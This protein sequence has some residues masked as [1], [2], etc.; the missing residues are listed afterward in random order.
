MKN[1]FQRIA[2]SFGYGERSH[3]KFRTTVIGSS[4]CSLSLP[5]EA[6]HF[7]CTSTRTGDAMHFGEAMDA[8]G[9]TYGVITICLHVPIPDGPSAQALLSTFMDALHPSFGVVHVSGAER[10]LPHCSC[11]QTRGI[12]DYWQDSEGIDWK[13]KGWTNGR[14]VAVLYVRNINNADACTA[15]IFLDSIRFQQQQS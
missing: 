11:L 1:L 10:D 4:S 3:G 2:S 6:S 8:S 7:T 5:A 13:V 12:S 15:D 9:V 14:Q